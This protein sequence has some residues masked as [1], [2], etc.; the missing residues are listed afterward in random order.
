MVQWERSVRKAGVGFNYIACF[1]IV[2]MMLLSCADVVLRLIGAPIPGA[3]E[4]VG[5]IGA[6]IVSLSLGRNKH[7]LIDLCFKRHDATLG[8]PRP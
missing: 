5:L 1:A 3:Y 6:L 4:M 8:R 2:V 7:I